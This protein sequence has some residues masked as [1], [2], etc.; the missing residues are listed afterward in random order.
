MERS[1]TLLN[2]SGDVTIIWTEESDAVIEAIIAKKMA[3]G[4]T[5]F[6]VEPVAGGLA[7]P[8]KTKLNDPE[9]ARNNRAVVIDDADLAAF[10]D[11]GA[12]AI[13]KS[14][15]RGRTVKRATDPKE[16]A[17]SSSVAVKQRRGG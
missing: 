15:K 8:R 1:L 16:V 6:I 11:T 14:P 4:I 9:Q 10:I 7:P 17:K 12:A 2:R 3:E 5:F 13:V